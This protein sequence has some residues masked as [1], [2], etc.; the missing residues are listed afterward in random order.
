[1][2]VEEQLQ[3]GEQILYR[4]QTTRIS[5]APR[6]AL[7]ALAALG[8]L[9][10]WHAGTSHTNMA[11]LAVALAVIGLVLGIWT[12][13][14]LLLLRS[15]EYIVTNLRLIQQTG[16]LTKRSMDV[17]LDKINNVEHRQ[18]IWGRL[19]GFG[20]LEIDTASETGRALFPD[21]GHPLQ[22]K[23]AIL[24]A[25]EDYRGRAFRPVVM[26]PPPVQAAPAPSAASSLSAIPPAERIRQL[27]KLLDE[28]LISPQEF[29]AK[30]RQALDEM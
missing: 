24:A 12:L 25:V 30:R 28:G 8:A 21:I 29:E 14:R 11:P 13:S 22:F 9:I 27:K 26:P 1:M 6:I 18:T 10:A 19:L 20:D 16:L 7:T 17:R 5:L 3:P 2:S 4:A 15:N 23:R